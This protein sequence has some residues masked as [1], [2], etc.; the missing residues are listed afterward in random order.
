MGIPIY[1]YEQLMRKGRQRRGTC[2]P[3]ALRELVNAWEGRSGGG[4]LN[5]G[6]I[7]IEMTYRWRFELQNRVLWFL[8]SL[9]EWEVARSKDALTWLFYKEDG[10]EFAIYTDGSE[11]LTVLKDLCVNL[12]DCRIASVDCWNGRLVLGLTNGQ[13][14]VVTWSRDGLVQGWFTVDLGSGPVLQ[15]FAGLLPQ[16]VLSYS[17]Q[18]GLLCTD[19]N[20]GVTSTLLRMPRD[21]VQVALEF[22]RLAAFSESQVWH[23]SDVLR[24]PLVQLEVPLRPE[25]RLL[26]ATPCDDRLLLLETD[27]RFLSFIGDDCQ[28]VFHKTEN[29]CQVSC[30]FDQVVVAEQHLY[31]TSLTMYER[32]SEQQRWVSLGYS[33]IRAKYNI[34]KV[35]RLALLSSNHRDRRTLA[36]LADDGSVQSFSIECS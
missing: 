5:R 25:E 8:G 3:E 27:R 12:E 30:A 15:V 34:H 6:A 23:C 20:S 1:L 2:G 19:R 32:S 31:G 29:C 9:A 28:T 10:S 21:D 16:F 11:D 22:P 7:G 4:S 35:L 17:R 26:K 33:D 36:V 18:E 13:M 24:E 14:K